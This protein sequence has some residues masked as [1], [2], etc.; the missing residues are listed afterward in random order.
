MT[1]AFQHRPLSKILAPAAG[2]DVA[3]TP[4][5]A[6]ANDSA[7]TSVAPVPDKYKDKTTA[8]V[9]EM[10]QN[11]EK[12]LGRS[13]SEVGQYRGL[14]QDLSQLRRSEPV[15]PDEQEPL[16]VSGDDLL[17]SPVDIIRKVVKQDLDALNVKAE[18]R[19]TANLVTLENQRL[20]TDFTDLDAIVG[21]EAFH[22]FANRT[23][24]RRE[25]FN[26]AAQGEGIAQVRAARRLLEDYQ[27]FTEV[28][29]PVTQTQQSVHAAKQ[30]A[31]ESGTGIQP[32]PDTGDKIYEADVI[33]LIASDPEKYR[34]PSFQK[35]LV[36][37]IREGRF[38]KN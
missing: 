36:A 26:T 3:P 20:V 8:Q 9:I 13:R 4:A 17:E 10:H 6:A 5:G 22:E 38:V 15:K 29:K 18:E 31:T 1:S 12:E 11:A 19:E 30:V 25:D 21:S 16:D 7:T 37:A 32:A 24:G 28:T 34:S 33:K 35:D 23:S 14:V 27:D 2:G